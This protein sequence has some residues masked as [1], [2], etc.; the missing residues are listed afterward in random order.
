MLRASYFVL[1]TSYFL[2]PTRGIGGLRQPGIGS[3]LDSA[4][5]F[6]A[7]VRLLRNDVAMLVCLYAT[8]RPFLCK[9]IEGTAARSHNVDSASKPGR[10][11]RG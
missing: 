5:L 4:G 3:R 8:S 1:F 7:D 11:L 6:Y 2:L 9:A 10:P